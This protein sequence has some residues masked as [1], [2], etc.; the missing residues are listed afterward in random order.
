MSLD[1]K[2]SVYKPN[3][4]TYANVAAR[5]GED[6]PAS[7]YEE[8]T[9][10]LQQTENFHYRPTWDPEREL[11]DTRRTAVKMADWYAFRDPRQ[12]Y[13]G[14]YTIARNRLM[15]ACETNFAFVQKK[16]L[17]ST[18]E[19]PWLDKVQKFLM[20]LR[21]YEWGANMNNINISHIGY[22][23]AVTQ[24]A[25]FAAMDRL[26]I[27]QIIS[28][29]GLALDGSTGERLK[30][31]RE[32]WTQDP[33]WQGLRHVMEDSFVFDDWFEQ[34]VAQNVVMDGF[35][36]PLTYDHFDDEGLK[37]G[38]TALSM[39]TEFMSDWY[40]DHLRWTDALVKAAAAE[41]E[42]NRALLEGW[43]AQWA[44][45]VRTAVGPLAAFVLG[46]AGDEAVAAVE[47][48]LAQRLEKIGLTLA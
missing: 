42:D 45:R 37:Y 16:G 28:R 13:Y 35:V 1:I 36:Y 26:G 30:P 41:S 22:G 8:A 17:L 2:T 46:D 47:Q 7:R 48:S 43:L 4:Q 21:H 34:F 11:F 32:D 20:P 38:A 12:F 39:L 31:T 33:L 6:R 40:A 14:T 25:A 9:F 15:D 3:R 27:A 23:T 44:D 24:C 18:I 5:L 19:Q 29:I 10:D